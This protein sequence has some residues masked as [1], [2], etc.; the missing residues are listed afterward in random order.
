M[1]KTQFT[2]YHLI[3]KKPSGTSRGVLTT[4]ETWFVK[5][6]HDHSPEIFG[7][8]ECAL[9][10]GLGCDD[11]PEYEA[12]LQSL[13]PHLPPIDEIRVKLRD[14]PSILF[15]LETALADLENGGKR[16]IFPSPFSEGKQS[17]RINGL[18]WMG[19][20][21]EMRAQIIDKIDN[22]FSCIKLKIGA[23]DF[24]AEIDLL[25]AIRGEFD[26]KTIELR[27][28]ANGAFSPN[29]AIHKLERL[30]RLNIHSIEQPIKAGQWNEL[31]R[32]C[33]ETPIP[34]A[35][36]EELIGV[37]ISSKKKELLETIKP[38]YIILKPSLHGGFA[39]SEEWIS[40]AN[41]QNIGWWATS[42][43]ESNIGLNAIAQWCYIQNNTMPQGLGTGQLYTNNIESPLTL[44]GE[45]LYY[46]PKKR[47][48]LNL[49]HF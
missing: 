24:E 31:A 37:N 7:L 49:I 17:I 6:W 11:R 16:I 15:G 36:D 25:K 29:D 18:I 38:Q 47:W 46:L 34:I 40:L 20:K 42:A 13:T 44:E 3:F 1:L 5:V 8:G 27:V 21:E 39:G 48:D 10:R 23:I 4:K 33:A 9:F 41:Q 43:L 14:F 22:R 35:L 26:A 45:N 32:L 30:A 28:D 12:V 2:P 19:T